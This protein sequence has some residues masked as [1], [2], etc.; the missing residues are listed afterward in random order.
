IILSSFL[1]KHIVN[2]SCISD[3]T[4][5]LRKDDKNNLVIVDE[6]SMKKRDDG[7]GPKATIR[8]RGSSKNNVD[9]QKIR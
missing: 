1:K 3:P 4:H 2:E 8:R 5:F 7:K 6:E 9:M